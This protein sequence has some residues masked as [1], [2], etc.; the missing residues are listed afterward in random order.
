MTKRVAVL[1][2][3]S[4]EE[5][6]NGYGLEVQDTAC[7]AY[8]KQKGWTLHDVYKDEG[9]SGSRT[10]RPGFDRLMED[11]K[12]GKIDVVVVHKFDRVGRT[13]R[14][15]WRWIWQLE[16]LEIAIVSVTQEID[17]TTTHG[18][19][20]LQQYAA[21]A[22][23]EYNLIRERTQA[24]LQ[25]KANAGGWLGGQPPYG[26]RIEGKGKRG[27][28]LIIDEHEA[29]V[30][31]LMWSMAVGEALNTRE[32]ASRLNAQELYTR[33]GV[34]W[35]HTNLRAK[36]LAD[37]TTKAIVTFRNPNRSKAGHGAKLNKDGL[38][39]HGES[40]VIPLAPIFTPE[41]VADLV[42][43]MG[44]LANGAPKSKP[45][46]YPL[47]KRLFNACGG[48]YVGMKRTGRP[49]RWY[50][51]SGKAPRW[52]GGPQCDCDAVDAD[53][54]EVAVWCEVVKLLGDPDRLQ[55]MAAEWIGMTAGDQTSHADR[56]G[57]LDRQIVDRQ[58][59]LA[60]MVVDYAKAGLPAVTVQAATRALT[61]E[62]DQLRAMRAE[63]ASWLAETEAADQRAKDLQAL[64]LVARERLHDMTP[65]EQGEIL[66]LLDVKVTI[67]G[68]V[69]RPRLGAA[70][71]LTQS[72]RDAGRLVPDELTDNEWA[73][74]EPMVK[75]WEPAAHRL[76]PGRDVVNALLYKARTGIRWR[77]MPERFGNG[78]SI[79]SRYKRWADD[80]TWSCILDALPREGVPAH[81]PN[82]VPPL[83]VEGRVDPRMVAG[84]QADTRGMGVP[85][86]CTSGL[87]A[88]V[89]ELLRGEAVVVT[90]AAEVVEMVGEIGA[91][92]APV[93]RGHALPRDG[94]APA[95][96][97][98]LEALPGRGEATVEALS[99][100][101]GAA[102]PDTLGRLHELRALG[103]V[104][105]TET[106]WAL[107]RTADGGG[108][109]RVC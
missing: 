35:S 32:M 102:V 75:A 61:E 67:T 34:P 85:G 13:G 40:V 18:K 82:L 100:A 7:M 84:T 10:S 2:R 51:C 26:Y 109:G 44:R 72:F 52:P 33:S 78:S 63:A 29:R 14:A 70:C 58:K 15:F 17:T 6:V 59:A 30:L 79:H 48:H 24:G 5:Q 69:P 57:D 101:A 56:I 47:S 90:D 76:L 89:H 77:D 71:S 41:E 106:G 9:V 73:A 103:F 25:A 54:I 4:T 36:L 104:E 68:P 55:A 1:E 31:R 96:A 62:L 81:V 49:G 64:A 45:Y 50:R 12:A 80:G 65:D 105:H 74:V 37:S 93:R 42:R 88:G 21:F 107:V 46:G 8:V 39:K 53:A 66:A 60:T 98:V 108:T 87:S 38:P 92:L 19:L 91:D 23:L 20:M 86:P 11:A 83:R 43:A 27:S 97:R 99:A 94:L 95:A 3:V 22:E 28:V 16:D